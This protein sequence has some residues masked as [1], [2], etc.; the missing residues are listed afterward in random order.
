MF[1]SFGIFE[2]RNLNSIG[3]YDQK[4]VRRCRALRAD[5]KLIFIAVFTNILCVVHVYDVYCFLVSGVWFEIG[6]TF[7]PV[8][9]GNFD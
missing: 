5:A 6:Y 1:L 4:Y 8:V 2:R 3:I 9:L 7:S